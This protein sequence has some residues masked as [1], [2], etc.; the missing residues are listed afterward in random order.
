[1]V[2]KQNLKVL[3]IED[4]TGDAFIVKF[5]LQ[6]SKYA[7]YEIVHEEDLRK[8]IELAANQKFDIVLLDLH[9]IDSDEINSLL[10]FQREAPDN[11]VIVMTGMYSEEMGIEALKLGAQDYLLKG[12]F[13]SKVFNNAVRFAYERYMANIEKSNLANV[14]DRNLNRFH[15]L[16]K[17]AQC[18]YFEVMSETQQVFISTKL[19]NDFMPSADREFSYDQFAAFFEDA[20]KIK[21]VLSEV[22]NGIPPV[23]KTRMGKKQVELIISDHIIVDH[24]YGGIL[25]MIS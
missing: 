6:E 14:F 11:F 23:I 16:Q 5:Y 9:F 1:M 12:A 15:V 7:N 18:Y 17:L 24:Q 2:E 19:N 3:L 21:K 8:G 22:R 4:N 25:K 10:K 20:D 13:D